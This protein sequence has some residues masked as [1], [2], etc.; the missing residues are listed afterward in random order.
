IFVDPAT[1]LKSADT[2]SREFSIGIDETSTEYTPKFRKEMIDLMV[3]NT[4]NMQSHDGVQHLQAR[5]ESFLGQNIATSYRPC[6]SV[7]YKY[8]GKAKLDPPYDAGYDE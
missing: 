6:T 7:F 8:V 4:T 2:R 3:A 1:D 5:E